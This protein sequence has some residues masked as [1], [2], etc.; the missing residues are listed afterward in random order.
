MTM[1]LNAWTRRSA[2]FIY[3]LINTKRI[4]KKK[5]MFK[6]LSIAAV[7]VALTV[8]SCSSDDDPTPPPTVNG[9]TSSTDVPDGYKI[10]FK[11]STT[12]NAYF[13]AEENGE[14]TK[15]SF[16]LTPVAVR[17]TN[18]NVNGVALFQA[19]Q[20]SSVT[21]KD[22]TYSFA[23]K[24]GKVD[25]KVVSNGSVE[26]FSGIAE[27]SLLGDAANNAATFEAKLDAVF[28]KIAK[29]AAIIAQANEKVTDASLKAEVDGI[30]ASVKKLDNDAKALS[31]N[32]TASSLANNAPNNPLGTDSSGI[33]AADSTAN[34]NIGNGG[35][36]EIDSPSDSTGVNV[37]EIPELPGDSTGGNTPDIPFEPG[38]TTGGNT[39]DIPFEPGDTMSKAGV[40]FFLK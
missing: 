17:S 15:V 11:N 34:S 39:P 19:G 38:D 18:G 40:K 9:Y 13:V 27:A 25:V 2:M 1:Y 35:G 3:L 29:A 4:M 6:F 7:A 8:T 37:P 22:V 12:G 20:I 30:A 33:A 26:T 32:G 36:W 28:A 5:F 24:D 21:I 14:I 31:D 23:V 16:V 10:G